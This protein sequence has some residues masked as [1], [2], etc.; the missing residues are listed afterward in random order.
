MK[1]NKLHIVCFTI[2]FPVTYGGVFDLFY[3]LKALNNIGVEIYLHCIQYGQNQE[4][5]EL[6]KFCTQVFYYKRKKVFPFRFFG[7]PYIV[8]SRI[9]P[10]LI[11]KL[12]EDQAPVLIEGIHCSGIIDYIQ[13]P[14]RKIV[15]RLPNVEF[16]YYKNLAKTSTHL[17]KKLYYNLE[18]RRLEIWEKQ[19]ISQDYI[20]NTISFLDYTIYKNELGCK[21]VSYIP[22]FI[23]DWKIE[24]E[25]GKGKYCLYQGNLD[26]EENQ[27]AVN[28]LLEKI[29]SNLNIPICIAG[30]CKSNYINT[31]Q[32]KHPNITFIANP[33]EEEM[34][35]LIKEAQL[36]LLPSF[37][38]TGIKLKLLNA[39]Y[40]GRFCIVNTAT[41]KDSGLE[42][43]CIVANS[44]SEF[45]KAITQY[46]DRPFT[47]E[48]VFFRKSILEN[49][50]SSNKNAILL[51]QQLFGE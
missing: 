21:Q 41:I 38:A 30:K 33:S 36:H 49:I 14:N 35:I 9:I 7:K 20:F 47:A 48:D 11:D 29:F 10:A 2:P 28:W 39:L 26:V 4:Q 43:L 3:K 24:I 40:N 23:P 45:Q 18:S 32:K 27:E 15:I 44:P 13:S 1:N 8:E 5:P 6:E 25:N 16:I 51:K 42:K 22:I 37:N 31:M 46:F 19:L 17:L 50:Y 34:Q 12:N